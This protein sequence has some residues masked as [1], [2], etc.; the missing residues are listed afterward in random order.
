MGHL[1][2]SNCYFH[3]ISKGDYPCD[4]TGCIHLLTY[5]LTYQ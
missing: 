2:A 4:V 1:Y 3:A 5:L